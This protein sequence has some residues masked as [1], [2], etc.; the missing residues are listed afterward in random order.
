MS[1]G[2]EGGVHVLL[3]GSAPSEDFAEQR[4]PRMVFCR[5]LFVPTGGALARKRLGKRVERI[6]PPP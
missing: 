3:R 6:A 4:C 5:W 1:L 2:A